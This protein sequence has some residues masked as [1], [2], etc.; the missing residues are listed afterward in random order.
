M[1]KVPAAVALDSSPRRSLRH[2]LLLVLLALGC[3]LMFVGKLPKTE[4]QW[5]HQAWNFGHIFLFAGLASVVLLRW[6]AP[7]RWQI[8]LLLL[9]TALIGFV[10]EVVQSRIGRDYS[11]RD[12]LLD[13][14]GTGLGILLTLRTRLSK[15]QYWALAV[16][17]LVAGYFVV[18]PFVKVVWDSIQAERQFPL[19]AGFDSRLEKR[20]LAFF[21]GA[22]G[23]V[24]PDSKAVIRFGREQWSGFRFFDAP[25]DWRGRRS[26]V[27]VFENPELAPLRISC[28]IN[29]AQHFRN[30]SPFDD[31]FTRAFAL[32]PGRSDVRIDL[33][34]VERAPAGRP[35]N[36][37]EIVDLSCFVHR[38]KAQ[39]KV[40]LDE[41]RL[42]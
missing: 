14:C 28:R 1:H 20:R 36:M 21:G 2:V 16:P 37:A 31:R 23:W 15:L 41:V 9:G 42:E 3:V 18:T 25:R 17:L 40:W 8:P 12:V 32:P 4:A 26:L 35:M 13:V 10:I 6:R 22:S 5:L 34:E 27:L 24:R 39:R 38:L 30:N 7:L 33:A 19:I 29:D 11:L